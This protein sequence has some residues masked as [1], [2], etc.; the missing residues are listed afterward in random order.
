MPIIFATSIYFLYKYG[1]QIYFEYKVEREFRKFTAPY[2]K[3]AQEGIKAAEYIK[4]QEELTKQMLKNDAYGGKTPEETLKLFVDALKKKDYKLAAKYYL[5]W[6]QKEAE[7]F[8]KTWIYDYSD[9]LK[10]FL[11]AYSKQRI[12]RRSGVGIHLLI[13][14]GP[15]TKDHYTIYFELNKENGIWKISKF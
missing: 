6:K 13:F 10:K 2:I 12:E 11:D 8:V 1:Y 3:K 15:N 5:P 4:K 14:L 7:K 9:G